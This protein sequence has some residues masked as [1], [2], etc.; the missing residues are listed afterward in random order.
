MSS[1]QNLPYLLWSRTQHMNQYY[2]FNFV[3]QISHRASSPPT[4]KTKTRS[5]F[6]PWNAS[7]PFHPCYKNAREGEVSLPCPALRLGKVMWILKGIVFQR[8][9]DWNMH[10][11]RLSWQA[12]HFHLTWLWSVGEGPVQGSGHDWWKVWLLEGML[13]RWM[14]MDEDGMVS[15]VNITNFGHCMCLALNF[16]F[17]WGLLVS[18]HH[19]EDYLRVKQSIR[20]L[21][22][23]SCWVHPRDAIPQGRAPIDVSARIHGTSKRWPRCNRQYGRFGVMGK[24][25]VRKISVGQRYQDCI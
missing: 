6:W 20:R 19:Y 16:L 2:H 23:L 15:P 11:C 5:N 8:S 13:I 12:Y 17:V 14:K 10:I 25:K 18:H 22:I 4:F 3:F 24:S 7:H 21:V 9:L 1:N